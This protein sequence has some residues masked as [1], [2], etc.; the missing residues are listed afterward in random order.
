MCVCVCAH[1]KV[2]IT[3]KYQ[4]YCSLYLCIYLLGVY[5][6]QNTFYSKINATL[7][8]FFLVILCVCVCLCVHAGVITS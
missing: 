6:Y 4:M 1:A 8:V 2:L 5:P 3:L 7:N